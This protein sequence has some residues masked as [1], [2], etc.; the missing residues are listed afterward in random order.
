M[1]EAIGWLRNG[2]RPNPEQLDDIARNEQHGFAEN[3][4]FKAETLLSWVQRYVPFFVVR[5]QTTPLDIPRDH[6]LVGALVWGGGGW[7]VRR[8]SAI[9][10][11]QVDPAN[12]G[13]AQHVTPSEAASANS[14]VWS[15]LLPRLSHLGAGFQCLNLFQTQA[16]R[17]F[18]FRVGCTPPRGT[19]LF[20]DVSRQDVEKSIRQRLKR[21]I[22]WDFLFAPGRGADE[23]SS[24]ESPPRRRQRRSGGHSGQTRAQ[25]MAERFVRVHSLA[26]TAIFFLLQ[27]SP[28]IL[29]QLSK[30]LANDEVLR[31]VSDDSLGT[32]LGLAQ[33]DI[34][35]P[36]VNNTLRVF[37]PIFHPDKPGG[38]VNAHRVLIAAVTEL[39]RRLPP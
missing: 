21:L 24:P 34:T 23:S 31:G 29:E 15:F 30:E 6:R 20:D 36:N 1:L 28:E 14:N 3:G 19:F 22:N 17:N 2:P 25:A 32:L 37:A 33:S 35:R 11:E 8:L 16:L 39:R 9:G 10:F 18:A 5:H 27:S 7:F 4:D 12:R 13:R 38:N 26:T